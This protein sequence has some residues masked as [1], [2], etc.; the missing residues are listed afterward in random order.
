MINQS[1]ASFFQLSTLS[2]SVE[3]HWQ[4]ELGATRALLSVYCSS[5]DIRAKK[6]LGINKVDG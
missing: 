5:V 3:Y 1:P 6:Q 4:Q 2:Q